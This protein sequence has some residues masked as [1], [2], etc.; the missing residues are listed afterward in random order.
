MQTY[1]GFAGKSIGKFELINRQGAK[2][3][4]DERMLRSPTQLLLATAA[5]VCWVQVAHAADELLMDGSCPT[6]GKVCKLVCETKKLTSTCYGSD[7]KDICIPDPSRRGCKHCAACYGKDAAACDCNS[8][9]PK[10][11]F[12][13]RDWFACG[14]AQPRTVRVLTKYQAEKE[15]CWYHWE[16]VDA[17]CCDCVTKNGQ[18]GKAG[19]TAAKPARHTIYKPAP[20]NAQVGD[21]MAISEEEWVKLAAVLSPDP[22]EIATTAPP[23]AAVQPSESMPPLETPAKSPTFA[24]RMQQI[25]KK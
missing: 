14:C 19:Q 24:E 20:E 10:C 6:C 22:T 25:W 7:S 13:W 5:L 18:P 15:I 4:K 17:S 8:C 21:V 11:E 1:L 12:C 9:P 2:N 23:K 16:V 3:A